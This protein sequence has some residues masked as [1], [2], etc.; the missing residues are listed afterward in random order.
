[1]KYTMKQARI[2]V[3]LT[4]E[5][6]AEKLG[7]SDVTYRK[8]ERNPRLMSVGLFAAFCGIVGVDIDDIFLPEDLPKANN[9]E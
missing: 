5:K 4:G 2:G 7:I 9:G 1:M 8:Y 6:M 3:N